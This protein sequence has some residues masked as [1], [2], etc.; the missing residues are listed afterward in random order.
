TSAFATR[1]SESGA[2]KVRHRIAAF[3]PRRGAP[4]S[5][6]PAPPSMTVSSRPVR[7]DPHQLLAEIGAFQK[8]HECAGGAVQPLGDEFAVLDLTLAHPS[9]HVAQEIRMARGEIA[10]NKTPDGQAFCQYRAHHRRSPFRHLPL[11][12]VIL[13]DQAAYG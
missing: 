2:D 10:D 9:R 7:P 3:A 1:H 12:V 4:S 13:R 5:V 11:G 6:P 8:P